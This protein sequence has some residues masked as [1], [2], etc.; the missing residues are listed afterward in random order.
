MGE[1]PLMEPPNM[2]V[3]HFYFYYWI[4]NDIHVDNIKNHEIP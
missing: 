3:N 2:G 4:F 1:L